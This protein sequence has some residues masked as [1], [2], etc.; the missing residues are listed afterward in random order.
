LALASVVSISGIA[1]WGI[2][3]CSSHTI[4]SGMVVGFVGTA[5]FIIK[6]PV[7]V[8]L[9]LDSIALTFVGFILGHLLTLMFRRKRTV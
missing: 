8:T 1:S 5:V 3:K 9:V 4:G 7:S 6:K 2:K